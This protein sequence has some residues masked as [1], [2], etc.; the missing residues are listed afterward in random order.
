[1]NPL[2]FSLIP[3]PYGIDQSYAHF[4]GSFGLSPHVPPNAAVR[5]EI[6]LLSHSAPVPPMEIPIEERYSIGNR[7]R[8]RG[9][10]WYSREDYTSAIQCYR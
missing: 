1:M 9:N 2:T 4:L 7:K 3:G 10:F 6:E 8:L 5:L